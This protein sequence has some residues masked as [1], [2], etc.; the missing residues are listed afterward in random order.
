MRVLP[1]HPDGRRVA[2]RHE[3]VVNV[4]ISL[5]EARYLLPDPDSPPSA[6][7]CANVNCRILH[8]GLAAVVGVPGGAGTRGEVHCGDVVGSPTDAE[9]VAASG[10]LPMR[11]D[12]TLSK[13]SRPAS[14][15]RMA[16]A[17]LAIFSQSQKKSLAR[18]ARKMN[19]AMFDVPLGSSKTGAYRAWPS[20]LAAMRSR[21]PL[22][23]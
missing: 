10:E 12:S 14:A 15:R 9:L 23:T 8:P 17:S 19:R 21:R 20:G 16:T 7:A 18:G 1:L 3:V 22:R 13:G 4:P 2:D 11:L 5:D 6:F